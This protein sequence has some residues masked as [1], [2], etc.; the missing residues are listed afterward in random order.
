MS[1]EP[2]AKIKMPQRVPLGLHG[3]FVSEAML[4]AQAPPDQLLQ[5]DLLGAP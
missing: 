4:Q 3:A 5:G 1:S 2:L